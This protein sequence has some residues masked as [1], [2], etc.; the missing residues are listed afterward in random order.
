MSQ[1]G[2]KFKTLRDQTRHPKTNKPLTQQQ[3]AD[4]LLEKIKLV[5]SHVTIS[6]WE[7]SKTPINQNERELLLA[8][9]A[10][11]YEHGGCNSLKVANELLE[12]GNYR[13]L[14]TPETNQINPDWLN[15]SEETSDP[16]PPIE[17]LLQLPAKAYHALIGRQAE[18]QQLFEGFQQKM[19]ALFIVGLGGM[20]KTA[21]AREVAEQVLNAGLFEVIVWTSAKKEKFIDETIENIEQPDYS[22]DQ[23][24]NE[25]GRQ[26]NRLDILPLPLDEKRDAVK[27]LLL[28]TK[29]LI[30]LDNLESVENAEHLLEEVLAVRG[31]SQLLITSRHFIP[32]PLITQI[33]LG[34]LSQKQTVQFLRTESKLKGVDSVSQAGEKTL[35]RIHD[36]T[37]G[38]PLALKLVVGQIYWL[39]LEDVLQILA[40]AKFEEQ[41]RDFYRFVFK[42][43]WDL[44][45]LPAQ[46]VLVSMSVFS[47]TDGGTK[48]AILQVSRVE[49]PAFMPALKLLV[50]MSLVDPSQNLQQKR[51]TIHQLTQYFVLSD[52]VKKW[53]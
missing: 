43:S 9:I 46:K 35:K 26:C 47:V 30:V 6:N 39:A 2:P 50:F 32:H 1:F 13:T 21:L 29:A 38:A 31:Q 5:Y 4:L 36:A 53:G 33:R 27:F 25:I 18:Q 3:I 34:G 42:H 24:F 7:R 40:D 44:L 8:L 45:P 37:G 48:E 17:Q 15:E 16:S 10:I 12:A 41:D 23:L 19:P 11:L 22:L 14:N 20:G 52:I 28:Q 51:Y 49:Q